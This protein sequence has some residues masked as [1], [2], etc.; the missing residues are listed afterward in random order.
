MELRNPKDAIQLPGADGDTH[1]PPVVQGRHCRQVCANII[2]QYHFDRVPEPSRRALQSSIR[3]I[4]SYLVH[5]SQ[6]EDTIEGE[7][8]SWQIELRRRQIESPVVTVRVDVTPKTV[9]HVGSNVGSAL[10]RSFCVGSHYT[11]SAVQRQ[12]LRSVGNRRGCISANRLG[13]RKQF[14]QSSIQA[15]P[16]DS[17]KVNKGSSESDSDSAVVARAAL[18]QKVIT[19]EHSYARP[20]T[21]VTQ[22]SIKMGSNGGTNKEQ[23][24]ENLRLQDVWRQRLIEEGWEQSARERFLLAWAS[25]TLSLYNRQIEKFREFCKDKDDF[26]NVD[27]ACIADFLCSVA[28]KSSRPKSIVHTS[29][30]ALKGLYEALGVPSP[31]D[32]PLISRLSCALVKCETTQPRNKTAVMPVASFKELFI[33]WKDNESLSIK[34]LRLKCI[35]LLALYFMLRPSDISPKAMFVADGS[36]QQFVFS[37][38]NIV[39]LDDGSLCVTFHGIKNDYHR[40]GFTITMP[41]ASCPKLDAGL[42]LKCYINRTATKRLLSKSS[43]VFLSLVSPFQGLSSTGIASVL[44]DAIGLAG[45]GGQG[46]SA[47]S[48]RPTAATQAVASGCDTNIARQIGRWKSH[49]VFEEHYVHT[50][51]PHAFVDSAMDNKAT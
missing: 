50:I 29:L 27:T 6:A 12:I 40:D 21:N 42:A 28:E 32:S 37:T 13:A 35:T 25:S 3:P 44:Q 31:V 41:P 5:L 39:F 49:S 34:Q 4:P 51:V 23:R 11:A 9:Q 47:K 1:G 22:D 14:H 26:P 30:A 33:S 16:V 36:A 46:F 7:T 18:V 17:G 38:D 19:N 20:P 43:C 10:D 48:F 15:A 8:P 24:M 2:G 45:L